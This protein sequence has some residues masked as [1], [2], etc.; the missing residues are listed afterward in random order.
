LPEEGL[1]IMLNV[2]ALGL[3]G[4][5]LR[6]FTCW[7]NEAGN[8]IPREL[9]VEVRGR[10]G[11]LN[12]ATTKFAA[13]ARPI[14]TV[15]GFVANVLVGPVEVHLAYD[16]TPWH[17]E[18]AFLETFLP[19]ERGAVMAGRIVRSDLLQAAATAFVSFEAS[20]ERVGRALRQYEMALRY[21]F[22]GGEWLALSHLWM[23]VEALTDAVIKRESHRLG[24]DSRELAESFG[25]PLDDPEHPWHLALKHEARRRL[26]F[27]GDD[28]T[29]STPSQ[30]STAASPLFLSGL[31][32]SSPL[33]LANAA[34]SGSSSSSTGLSQ[35]PAAAFPS[36]G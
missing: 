3:E 22:V 20:S 15:V 6:A 14:A 34:S 33:Y 19:D 11:S 30:A 26:V 10:S 2:P 9:V 16:S 13:V 28:E 17:E 24:V 5:R 8:E 21:W 27:R 7:V 29:Y 36:G 23:A 32:P 1:E 25:L 31:P 4:L 35:P 12:E 18:R